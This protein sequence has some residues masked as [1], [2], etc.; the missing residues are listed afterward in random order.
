MDRVEM[1]LGTLGKFLII[2]PQN[3]RLKNQGLPRSFGDQDD[4]GAVGP[5]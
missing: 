3:G 4:R 2:G 1:A 5:E